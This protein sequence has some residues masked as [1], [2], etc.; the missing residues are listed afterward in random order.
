[1]QEEPVEPFAAW[2]GSVLWQPEADID[3]VDSDLEIYEFAS[4][5]RFRRTASDDDESGTF[6]LGYKTL[7]LDLQTTDDVLPERL[8]DTSIAIGYEHPTG[9]FTRWGV[10]GGIGY[11]GTEPF[12]D[13]DSIYFIGDLFYEM[14]LDR[15][16]KL[17]LLVSYD[18]N[19]AIWPD[20]PLPAFAYTRQFD[21]DEGN[22]VAVIGLPFS[23]FDMTR[24]DWRYRI[25]YS[26][27]FSIDAL[28]E[29]ELSEGLHLF[30][31]YDSRYRGFWMED[32]EDRRVFLSQQRVEGGVRLTT[33]GRRR[34]EL[35]AA[36]GYSF[37]QELETGWDVRDTDT[38]RE[39]DA[40]PYLRLGLDLA[41]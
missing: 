37:G 11:A 4:R 33:S 39:V 25:G 1:M 34:A 28:A 15:R 27:P 31:S 3:G 18:G 40:S 17:T 41:F 38:L 12:D 7:Y 2:S 35:V 20:V 21:S 26:V 6:A 19:R 30:G 22:A 36:A 8:S 16:S 29:Y 5:G 23:S 10:I 32:D 9:D 24:G 13:S 14:P